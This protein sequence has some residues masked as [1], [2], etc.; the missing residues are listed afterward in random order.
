MKVLGWIFLV[1]GV[2]SLI[3]AVAV[4]DSAFGP[5]FFSGLGI[6]FIYRAKQ[7]ENN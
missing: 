7:K 2:L 4:G 1:I 3:G 5:L 6:F